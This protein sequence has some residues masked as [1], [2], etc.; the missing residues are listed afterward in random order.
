MSHFNHVRELSPE[1]LRAVGAL[2]GAGVPVCNQTV[3]LRGVNDSV[4]ALESLFRALYHA[5]VRPY[6]L[7][8]SDLVAGVEH[9]RTPL[10]TGLSI[11]KEL[12]VRLSGPALPNFCLDPPG[13]GGKI[14]LSPD[15]FVSRNG[16]ETVLRNGRGE[17][18]R[19]P[20]PAPAAAPARRRNRK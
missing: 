18:F 11:M 13:G 15:Y 10:A 17:I 9:L 3:L 2:V 4:E 12:R 5:R 20:D 19:Y 16:S 6:Y 1:S 14:E 8:Q 7:F